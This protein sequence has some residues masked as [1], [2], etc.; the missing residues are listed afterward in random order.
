MAISCTLTRKG[1]AAQQSVLIPESCSNQSLSAGSVGFA[2][3]PLVPAALGRFR[4]IPERKTEEKEAY[5][6]E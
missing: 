5:G 4:P 1:S 6:C 3:G 2:S